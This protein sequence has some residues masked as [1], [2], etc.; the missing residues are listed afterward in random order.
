MILPYASAI[1][2]YTD[3][4]AAF[5]PDSASRH[6]FVDSAMSPCGRLLVSPYYKGIRL[7]A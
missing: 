6:I 2:M 4:L 5:C 7:Y 3:R 1:G